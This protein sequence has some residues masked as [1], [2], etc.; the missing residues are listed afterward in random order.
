MVRAWVPSGESERLRALHSCQVLDTPP[1]PSFDGIALLA[2]QV[3]GTPMA[4]VSL[5]DAERQW[6]KARVGVAVQE[7]PRDIAFCGHTILSDEPLVV[8]DAR[9]DARFAHNPLVTGEP[10]V[11]FYAGLPL[12]LDDGSRVGSLCVLDRE[13][14]HLSAPQMSALAALAKQVSTELSLRRKL[15]SSMPP[16]PP[17]TSGALADSPTLDLA[18]LRVPHA[19]LADP[20]LPVPPGTLVEQRYRVEALLGEGGMGVVCRALDV[21][22]SKVVA[23]K[24][25]RADAMAR[26]DALSRFVREA[27][28]LLKMESP[29]VARVLDVGNLPSH[30]PFIVM[31]YLRGEDLKSRLDRTGPLTVRQVLNL[32]RQLCAALV[33][34]HEQGVLHRDLKP[35][36]L[37]VACDDDGQE[38]LKV[39][40]FGISKLLEGQAGLHALTTEATVLGS[41]QYMSPEQMMSG[42]RADA[43]SD[44]WSFG[45][46]LFELLTGKGPFEGEA[47]PEIC[48]HVLT[49]PATPLHE[50]RPD[51]PLTLSELVA[52]CLRK[53]PVERYQSA[54]E[55]ATALAS[56]EL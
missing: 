1:E 55:L 9:E 29:H 32:A 41:P 8:E 53:D 22:N 37:F 12:V 45:V 47:L 19:A 16:P 44:L 2:S 38:Q 25:M 46:V 21:T 39:L 17:M 15:A 40:D 13:P 50:L 34:A 42:S 43:R 6:F 51:V 11:R 33:A 10:H 24:F 4:L 48:A 56:V 14:R 18:T 7:T 5:V 27:Q 28:V 20:R 54:R 36:N 23:L 31:E 26:P 52:R 49:S 30:E 3:C 35:A